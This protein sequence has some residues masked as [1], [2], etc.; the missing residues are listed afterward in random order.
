MA[1]RVG[2]IVLRVVVKID[3]LRLFISDKR[4]FTART[5]QKQMFAIELRT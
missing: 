5:G 2:W 4:L 1:A 3:M